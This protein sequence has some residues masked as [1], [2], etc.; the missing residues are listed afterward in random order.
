MLVASLPDFVVM[1]AHAIGG[2]YKPKDVYDRCFC[3]DSYPGGV[4]ELARE[5][6]GRGGNALVDEAIGILREKDDGG[7]DHHKATQRR[8]IPFGPK[9]FVPVMPKNRNVHIKILAEPLEELD[10]IISFHT[11]VLR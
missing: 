7:A 9:M 5:L 10:R 4:G 1:K 8:R 2:L 3:L 6:R 11:Q